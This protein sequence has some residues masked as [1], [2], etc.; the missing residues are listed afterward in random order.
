MNIKDMFSS[1][2]PNKKENPPKNKDNVNNNGNP[3]GNNNNG[4]N[5][6]NGPAI[7]VGDFYVHNESSKL[8]QVTGF[9]KCV[10]KD[11]EG[12]PIEC[13]LIVYM[14]VNGKVFELN[15]FAFVQR[16]T[17]TF[18]PSHA[19]EAMKKFED[20]LKNKNDNK[21]KGIT[22]ESDST[23]NGENP[24]LGTLYIPTERHNLD[25]IIIFEEAKQDIIVGISAIQKQEMMEEK[26]GLSK[27]LDDGKKQILN[28]FGSSGC[29][30]T[31]A[32]R[33]V[34]NKLKKKIYQVDYA[35]TVSKW[36]G[37]TSKNISEIF[38]IAKEKDAILFFDEADALLSKR[39]DMNENSDYANS[40][41]NNR[42]VFMQELDKFNNIV[43]LCSNFFNNYDEAMLRRI[44]RHIEFKLPNR[45]MRE[46]LFELHIPNLERAKGVNF[47]EL[48][49]NSKGLSG[50]DIKN[51]CVNAIENISCQ[52]EN[53]EKWILTTELILKEIG[54]INKAKEEHKKPGSNNRIS[55][56]SMGF[57]G[58]PLE[59]L[60]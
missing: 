17:Q 5:G 19:L 38:R 11:Q 42:N 28:F 53:P 18:P 49:S 57:G 2:A 46:K 43:I 47:T 39:V 48:A 16:F 55:K 29:G 20:E 12:N 21:E 27:I 32:A 13:P 36:V 23:E 8:Y 59:D 37:E 30:K 6:N 35:Q 51:A 54:K 52:E 50:G 34:A 31:L 56:P 14:S 10:V 26:W 41:N 33:A 44:N 58:K 22:S 45:E 25:N 60:D 7:R 3:N 4:N 24:P 9:K 1:K 15:I 40:V